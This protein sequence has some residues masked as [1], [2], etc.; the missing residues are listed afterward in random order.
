MFVILPFE[1]EYYR[2]RGVEVEFV[3]HPLLEDFAPHYNREVFLRSLGLDP[4]WKTVAILS[5][6]RRRE[7]DYILPTLLKSAQL[8]LRRRSAQFIISAAPTVEMD[9]LR[10]ITWKV[11]E[12]DPNAACFRIV[13][14]N[15]RDILANSDF[16][17]VKSGTSTLEA[18][19]VGTPFLI[20]Y[21]ISPISWHLGN[22]LIHS[23]LKGLVNL[24]A[25]EE[26]VPEFLQGD[27]SPETLSRVA[28]EYLEEPEKAEHMKCRLAAIREMLSVRCAS[29]SVAAAAEAYLCR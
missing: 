22:L 26:I 14:A 4:Q 12:G 18:A 24:I 25:K 19:L 16:A 13:T 9:H 17:F 6:S 1:E 3:G 10:Q 11:L 8:I 5:G 27:A 28:L 21:K 23:S 20:T 15:S 2:E 7:V 29:E